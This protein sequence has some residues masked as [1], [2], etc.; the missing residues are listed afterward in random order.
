VSVVN[1][2][3]PAG[4]TDD[5]AWLY[6]NPAF[7]MLCAY[8]HAQAVFFARP[9]DEQRRFFQSFQSLRLPCLDPIIREWQVA[10]A[11]HSWWNIEISDGEMSQLDGLVTTFSLL[12]QNEE[13]L[14]R[15]GQS[16]G[17]S[18]DE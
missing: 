14:S 4:S 6:I 5:P 1:P 15:L 9:F 7:G 16:S 10:R 2:M 3:R 11:F 12:Q 18:P 17:T 13:L 8:G